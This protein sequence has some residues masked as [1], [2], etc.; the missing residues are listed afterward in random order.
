MTSY[1]FSANTAWGQYQTTTVFNWVDI[2]TRWSNTFQ[3]PHPVAVVCKNLE[4]AMNSNLITKPPL[5]H[6]LTYLNEEQDALK[7]F[8]YECVMRRYDTGEIRLDFLEGLVD[9]IEDLNSTFP[10]FP[11]SPEG[12]HSVRSFL[13]AN[14]SDQEL[15]TVS[16]MPPLISQREVRQQQEQRRLA[17]LPKITIFFIRSMER[18]KPDDT[19]NISEGPDGYTYVYRDGETK[20]NHVLK[21]LGQED[22]IKR[23]SNTLR[24]LAIDADPFEKV[25]FTFPMMPSITVEHKNLDAYT[26]ELIY[27]SIETTMEDWPSSK[28]KF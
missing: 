21:C 28:A 11:G 20:A 6:F 2:L 7:W 24:M 1:T 26:R 17:E 3:V 22:V 25:Q 27:E 16:M 4:A 5:Q 15:E 8:L 12:H 9:R 18:K 14:L 10:V 23:V 19:V 13:N